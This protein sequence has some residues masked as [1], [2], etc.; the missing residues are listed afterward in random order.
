MIYST[1][2]ALVAIAI[3]VLAIIRSKSKPKSKAIIVLRPKIGFLN[4][5]GEKYT[6]EFQQDYTCL[7]NLFHESEIKKKENIKCDVLFI[8]GD[9]GSN[10]RFID[11]SSSLREIIRDSGAV[12][13]VIATENK[14]EEYIQAGK[15]VGY[16]KTNLVMTLERNG[17]AFPSF[18]QELFKKMIEGIPMPVA[19]VELAP[20]GPNGGG[21][22]TPGT[23]CSLELGR[24]LFHYEAK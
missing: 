5:S 21:I 8:Y 13:V 10:G 16:G 14:I 22:N 11:Y 4:F 3:F 19:W 12:V 7:S 24:V 20:Q 23:I 17:L 18:F 2:L 15:K 9:I 6:K 1:F